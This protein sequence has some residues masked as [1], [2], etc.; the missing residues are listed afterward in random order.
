[1]LFSPKSI[2]CLHRRKEQ[3][4]IGKLALEVEADLNLMML[5]FL[6]YHASAIFRMIL[7]LIWTKDRS[8]LHRFNDLSWMYLD[9]A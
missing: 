5:L 4:L 2:Q 3:L 9:K 8:H 7:K 6:S 1:M